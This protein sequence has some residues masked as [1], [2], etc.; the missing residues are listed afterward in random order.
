VSEG[1][2]TVTRLRL[3]L[4]FQTVKFAQAGGAGPAIT[5]SPRRAL[6]AEDLA[7]WVRAFEAALIE[8]L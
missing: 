8:E 5:I 4:G 2:N 3:H 7:L 6:R 1:M